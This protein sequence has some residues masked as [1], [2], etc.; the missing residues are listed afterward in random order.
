MELKDAIQNRHSEREFSG[1]H[2]TDEEK[3]LFH[4]A[5]YKVPSAGALYP[6]EL[7]LVENLNNLPNVYVI[8]ADFDKTTVKYGERGK[9]YVYME[10]GHTAQNISLLAVELNLACYCI[11]AFDEKQMQKLL[12]TK[13]T[14]IYM[15]A[16]G[17]K[18]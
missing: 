2:L 5:A 6:L 16:I 8:C 11:G 7:F 14:P 13:L 12:N 18:K 3:R 9:G 10:A 1:K 17:E 15:V 4:W